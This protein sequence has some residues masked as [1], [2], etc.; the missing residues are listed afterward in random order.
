MMGPENFVVTSRK[1]QSPTFI[2]SIWTLIKIQTVS[3]CF[4]HSKRISSDISNHVHEP[5]RVLP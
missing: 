5:S 1:D 3:G 2:N 4:S